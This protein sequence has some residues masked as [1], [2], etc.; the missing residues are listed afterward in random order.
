[1]KLINDN[2]LNSLDINQIEANMD[3]VFTLINSDVKGLIAA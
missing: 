2:T 3:M 1:V